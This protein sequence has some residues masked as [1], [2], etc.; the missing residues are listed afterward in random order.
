M[1][2]ASSQF[3]FELVL[4][5]EDA[6]KSGEGCGFLGGTGD[7]F[8]PIRK[9]HPMELSEDVPEDYFGIGGRAVAKGAGSMGLQL[10]PTLLLFHI[11]FLLE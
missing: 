5:E 8:E 7:L 2:T 4:I 6:D 1:E 10:F 3:E 11:F 9:E